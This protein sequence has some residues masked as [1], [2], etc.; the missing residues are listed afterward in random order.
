M[1]APVLQL[2]LIVGPVLNRFETRGSRVPCCAAL[3]RIDQTSKLEGEIPLQ[4]TVKMLPILFLRPP[5]KRYFE[6]IAQGSTV[7]EKGCNCS[8]QTPDKL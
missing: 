7:S 3:P 8:A 5:L 6:T 4:C 2:T 1:F